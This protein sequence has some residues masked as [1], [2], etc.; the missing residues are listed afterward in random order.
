M[1]HVRLACTR[2]PQWP[3]PL[4]IPPAAFG[5]YLDYLGKSYT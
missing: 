4:T 3:M 5:A 1:L 2:A